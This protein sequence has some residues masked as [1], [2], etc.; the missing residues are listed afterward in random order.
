MPKRNGESGEGGGRSAEG[1]TTT[2]VTSL[3]REFAKAGADLEYFEV[4]R[5]TEGQYSA[6]WRNMGESEYTEPFYVGVDL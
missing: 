6:V 3:V 2:I 4:Q 1:A 5:L